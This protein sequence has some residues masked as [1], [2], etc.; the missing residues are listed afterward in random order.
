MG[1][2]GQ[3]RVRRAWVRCK[4]TGKCVEGVDWVKRTSKGV[5]GCG[6]PGGECKGPGKGMESMGLVWRA[7]DRCGGPRV[8]VEGLG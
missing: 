3:G 1:V 5:E 6:G 7:I 8:S 2:E 4:G